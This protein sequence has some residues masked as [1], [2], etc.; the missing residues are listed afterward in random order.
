[1]FSRKIC[2]HFKVDV[3]RPKLQFGYFGGDRSLMF[4]PIMTD[5][6]LQATCP[7]C[8][9]NEELLAERHKYSIRWPL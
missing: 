7:F 3:L 2:R 6:T 5:R 1:M 4:H 9:L 8:K